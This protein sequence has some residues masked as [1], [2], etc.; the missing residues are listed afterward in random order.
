[1]I[2][3]VEN[4]NILYIKSLEIVKLSERLEDRV[5]QELLYC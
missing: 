1:M 4:I 2:R 3:G 5:K